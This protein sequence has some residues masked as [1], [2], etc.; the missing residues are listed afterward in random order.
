MQYKDIKCIDESWLDAQI[1]FL[2]HQKELNPD[3]NSLQFKLEYINTVKQHLTSAT[4]ILEKAFNKG[5]DYQRN[6]GIINSFE[7]F[8]NTEVK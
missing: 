1:R 7:Q 8:L 5:R 2:E 3:D 4:P 6:F